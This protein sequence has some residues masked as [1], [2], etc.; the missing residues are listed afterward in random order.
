MSG[1]ISALIDAVGL[2]IRDADV[3]SITQ[4][5]QK[6]TASSRV[7]IEDSI[8]DESI[9]SDVLKNVHNM[10]AGYI[11]VAAQLSQYVGENRRVRDLL[12]VVST[13]SFVG[14]EYLEFD[15]IDKHFTEMFSNTTVTMASPMKLPTKGTIKPV[16]F[17]DISLPSGRLIEI[18]FL[19]PDGKA[20]FSTNMFVQLLPRI[21]PGQVMEQF[22]AVNI[23]MD[24]Q[25][26]WLQYKTGE[27]N[28]W[29]DF[30]GQMDILIKRK[31]ALKKDKTGDL[32]DMFDRQRSNFFTHVANIFGKANKSVQDKKNIANSILIFD[33]QKFDRYCL[34]NNIKFDRFTE[35]QKFFSRAYALFVITIDPMYNRVTMYING[36]DAKC[37]YTYNQM[38][39]SSKQEKL[40]LAELMSAIQ[41]GQAPKF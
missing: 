14:D 16:D 28:F 36:L 32:R 26:R 34:D 10:Y 19:H 24:I 38:I 13:E 23:S 8:V 35:R 17:K 27:I 12:S 6:Y 7:Y 33:K 15:N 21:I 22:L 18:V 4:E 1:N 3:I 9:L 20:S 40:S 37:E 2:M 5:A 31:A 29:K 11:L 30:V 25:K 41:Q 39:S